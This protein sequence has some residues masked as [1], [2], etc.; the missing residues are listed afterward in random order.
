MQFRT[1]LF[2]LLFFSL[3]AHAQEWLIKSG[4]DSL[5][6]T[7]SPIED[8]IG[9]ELISFSGGKKL[10]SESPYFRLL[11]NDEDRRII[12]KSAYVDILFQEDSI[13]LNGFSDI[14]FKNPGK[15]NE[16]DIQINLYNAN[17]ELLSLNSNPKGKVRYSFLSEPPATPIIG[18]DKIVFGILGL[19]LAFVF[20]TSHLQNGGWKKFYTIIPAL[21][22]CYMIP[23]ALTSLNLIDPDTS[24]LYYMASRYLLPGSLILL[25]L[26]A[27]IKGL[28][29]LGSKSLIMF[30]TGTV[31]IILG[32]VFVMWFFGMI[33]PEIVGGEG[34]AASWR[35]FATIAGSWIGGGANQSAMLETYK[36]KE[37]LFGGMLLV[38]IVVANIWM[39][40]ILFGIGKTAKIDK[41]LKADS[42][43]IDE[44]VVKV[45]NFQ[46]SVERKA[47]LT[48]FMVILGLVFA[49]V[50]LSHFLGDVLAGV[51]ESMWGNTSTFASSFFWMVVLSTIYGLIL[52][53]TRAKNYEGVGASK[54]GSVFLYI[55][56]ATIGMKVDISKVFDKP[57][58]IL[59]G[60]VWMAFHAGLLILM[61]K[62]IR[63]PF[64][65]LAVGSQ[66]NVGGAASAPIVA[67][68]FHPALT[69]VGVIMAVFGYFI[70]TFGAII[71]AELMA[72]L[73]P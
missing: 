52:S 59:V 19:I 7:A 45:E 43:A 55:L 1:I 58:L 54:I 40:V 20:Y 70:G 6:I 73:A 26:S 42:S 50:G 67:N 37:S 21:F 56:V 36:Y 34:D 49:G 47:T 13:R 71:C 12:S 57:A 18:D 25:I 10:Y 53:F 51:F 14:L 68:A 9:L 60:L 31:G 32:G 41:W 4:K 61:A 63:A 44:L 2:C 17:G 3:S 16:V 69:T 48:D 46:K 23:A 27:D 24:G 8:E 66:A 38:D 30:F 72:L 64:F 29:N 11:F 62:L 35:G 28:F 39:A 65:F 5:V 15:E 22:L 33:N